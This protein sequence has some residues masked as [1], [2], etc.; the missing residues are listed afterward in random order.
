MAFYVSVRNRVSQERFAIYSDMILIWS[1]C[2]VGGERY[3]N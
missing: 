3:A 2:G 1:L